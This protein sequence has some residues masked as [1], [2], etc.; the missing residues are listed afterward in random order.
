[1][2]SLGGSRYLATVLLLSAA[3]LRSAAEPADP[4]LAALIDEAIAANPQLGAAEA[5]AAAARSRPAQ[6]RSLPDPLLSLGY[7]ND[8]WAPTLGTRD[9]T[10]LALTGSQELPYPGKLGLRGAIAESEARQT[11]QR[12]ARVRRG[13]VAG[14]KRAYASLLL[15]RDLRVLVRQKQD[16]W[17]QIEGV[18]RG[19]YAV[20]QGTQQDVVRAQIE[21]SRSGLLEVEQAAQEQSSLAE[22]NGLLARPVTQPLATAAPLALLPVPESLDAALESLGVQSPEVRAAELGVESSKLGAALAQKAYKPDLSV[23]A[24]Y[25]NRRG[26]DPMWQAAVG[27]NLPL[28]RDRLAAGVAEAEA[29]R[30]TAL[31]SVEATR[32]LLRVRTQQRLAVLAATERTLAIY[33]E[34]VLPQDRLAV[35]AGLAGYRADRLPFVAVLE[36]ATALYE[37]LATRQRVLASHCQ[38]LATLEEASLEAVPSMP[39]AGPPA[40]VSGG[41]GATGEMAK[42]AAGPM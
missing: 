6:A 5:L 40:G 26:L 17:E 31:R 19:R 38:L 9:M 20:G 3:P 34:Q 23:Q 21:L 4:V 14:V 7:T 13:L 42:A 30:T 18:V 39:G 1:M 15:A 29:L 10:L 8:G 24:G 16:A 32:L 25:M 41:S 22:L 2:S 28:H 37:D 27:F 12:T 11:E 36:A 35:D 33:D